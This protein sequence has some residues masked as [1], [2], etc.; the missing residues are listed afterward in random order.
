MKENI[1]KIVAIA[2]ILGLQIAGLASVHAEESTEESEKVPVTESSDQKNEKFILQIKNQL[3]NARTDYFQVSKN[4]D[5]AKTR[6][7]ATGDSIKSLKAQLE[8]YDYL[9]A[10]SQAKIRNVEK[11]VS[12]KQNLIELYREEIK[13]KQIELE[14][15]KL[16]LRDYLKVLY[17]Q[18]NSFLNKEGDP[19]LSASKL[20]LG[21]A[22]VGDTFKEIEYFAILEQT[23]QNIFNKIETIQAEYKTARTELQQTRQK[24]IKLDAQLDEE[25]KTLKLQRYAKDQLL[26][27]TQGEEDI[28][29]ELIAQ[30]KREQLELVEEI[31]KLK[32]NL[33]FIEMKIQEDGENFNPDNYQDLIHPN[34]RAVYD[35]EMLGDFASGEKLN[36][37]VEPSRGLSAYF[38]DSSYL[39]AFGIPH[40]AIDIPVP[41][42]T[43]VRAP[44][45]GVVYKIK[46]LG[47][48]NYAYII[49]AHKGGLLTVYGHMYEIMVDERDVVLPGEVIGLSGGI[50]GTKGAGFLT[51]GAHLHFETIKN[52]KHVDPL[53]LMDLDKLAEEYI[54]EHFKDLDL[55]DLEELAE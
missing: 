35:F 22:G 40:R 5:E 25:K 32:E 18:E 45:S 24:L 28:Y 9:I 14:N 3:Q 12:Q 21:D 20:L 43:P 6:L 26:R 30:S 46:D 37:P 34:V 4:I 36:W 48:T 17:L 7:L 51:T 16:I 27:Q 29:R 8:N 39:K 53:Y 10:N 13:I 49:I 54:P 44:S 19:D 50:P 41:Q 15:Q 42:G 47:D 11:Q 38:A 52:G 23:G 55:L 1:K 2:L 31:N 33:A